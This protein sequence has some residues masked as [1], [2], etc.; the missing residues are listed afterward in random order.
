MTGDTPN[1]YIYMLFNENDRCFYIGRSNDPERRLQEHIDQAATGTSRKC[2]YIR[3]MLERGHAPTIR[4]VD[5]AP[6]NK[7]AE[8]EAYWI[9]AVDCTDVLGYIVFLQNGNKGSQGNQ[10]DQVKLKSDIKQW[11]RKKP[12][13]T[14]RQTGRRGGANPDEVKRMLDMY[15]NDP[16][17]FELERLRRAELD[18]AARKMRNQTARR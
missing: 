17:A 16:K 3:E 12:K 6:A 1:H 5:E 2:R 4:I 10:I 13:T 18:A 14:V 8:V 9:D 11:K 15:E 7:I